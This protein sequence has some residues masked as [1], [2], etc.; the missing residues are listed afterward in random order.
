VF[1]LAMVATLLTLWWLV[2]R[3]EA[4][5]RI[6]SPSRQPSPGE[7]LSEIGTLR[8]RALGDS[9]IDTLERVFIGVGLAALVGVGA[10]I[11]ASANRGV[12]AV[13]N[14]LVIFLRS[15]PMGALFPLTLLLFSE[16]RQKTMF[17]FLALVAFVFSDTVKAMMSVPERFVETAQ[18]L[19]ASRFQIIRKV[20]VPLALPDIIT[21][22]RFQFGLALGYV[23]LAEE[24]NTRHGLG[25]LINMSQRLG[26]TEHVY[27][28]L[29]LIAL[30]AFGIDL[31]LRTLQ[32]G[33]FAWRKDL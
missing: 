20:L 4:E 14:P 25:Q 9:I 3:V 13:L 28:L 30:L 17:L 18:T 21:S 16:H 8:Q 32:R 6:I 1:G 7:V 26:P 22:L 27:L 5:F 19:G 31:I 2:T 24:Y 15:V 11:F 10:G 33:V 29:L 23:M 12:G